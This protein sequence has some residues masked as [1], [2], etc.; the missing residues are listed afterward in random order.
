MSN[1][2]FNTT[3]INENLKVS[4]KNVN[5]NNQLISSDDLLTDYDLK[6]AEALL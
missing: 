1:L 3:M 5:E 4:A 6:L 2:P